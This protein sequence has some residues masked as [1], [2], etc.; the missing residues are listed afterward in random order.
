MTEPTTQ[1][2]YNWEKSDL[3]TNEAFGFFAKR[4]AAITAVLKNPEEWGIFLINKLSA[5]VVKYDKLFEKTKL[6]FATGKDGFMSVKNELK[7]A[8]ATYRKNGSSTIVKE[9]TI[10]KEML[11]NHIAQLNA[12][13]ILMIVYVF[14]TFAQVGHGHP[15]NPSDNN[16]KNDSIDEP[17]EKIVDEILPILPGPTPPSDQEK[18][19]FDSLLDKL[20]ELIVKDKAALLFLLTKLNNLQSESESYYKFLIDALPALSSLSIENVSPEF[21][22]PSTTNTVLAV[23]QVTTTGG[24]AK[25]S[26]RYQKEKVAQRRT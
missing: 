3:I 4:D 5:E 14:L 9:G 6:V 13:K 22:P 19:T 8:I 25:Q 2:S 16:V 24:K 20:Q 15:A 23:Q 21:K 11:V 12:A 26:D 10:D 1:E 17:V 18:K 7:K